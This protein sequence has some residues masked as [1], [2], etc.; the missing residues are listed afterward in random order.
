M[1]RRRKHGEKASA[2]QKVRG[3]RLEERCDQKLCEAA[4]L[5]ATTPN[6]Y[7]RAVVT[8]HLEGGTTEHPNTLPPAALDQFGTF[9]H[10]VRDELLEEAERQG[11]RLDALTARVNA[12]TEHVKDL[13]ERVQEVD[14]RLAD[15]LTRVEPM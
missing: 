10:Q 11:K 3:F 4:S 8:T 13:V 6:Q 15:F 14:Q 7:A 1:T 9:L 5:F 12:L 2:K